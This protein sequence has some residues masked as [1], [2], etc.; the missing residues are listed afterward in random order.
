MWFFLRVPNN[1]MKLYGNEMTKE[2][3]R[4]EKKNYENKPQGILFCFASP[5]ILFSFRISW[6]TGGFFSLHLS[7]LCG[8]CARASTLLCAVLRAPSRTSLFLLLRN[9]LLI[10]MP[11]SFGRYVDG[12]QRQSI[13]G[14]GK[15]ANEC[16]RLLNVAVLK[17]AECCVHLLL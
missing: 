13:A 14:F 8:E 10:Q 15:N 5:M 6:L 4:R 3:D 7:F 16:S 9:C 1:G 2:Q 17:W 11:I 12:G